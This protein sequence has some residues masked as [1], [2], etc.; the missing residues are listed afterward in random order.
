MR[1]A[2]RLEE[3]GTSQ[4]L[5]ADITPVSGVANTYVSHCVPNADAR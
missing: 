1:R 3:G 5:A 4:T 2:V